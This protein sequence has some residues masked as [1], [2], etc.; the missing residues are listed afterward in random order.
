MQ[1]DEL[2]HWGVKGMK[3]G[4]RKTPEQKAA[5]I[6]RRIDKQNAKAAKYDKQVSN[7]RNN[8][9]AAA[10]ST[11]LTVNAMYKIKKVGTIGS[12][13][14]KEPTGL[15]VATTATNLPQ[16]QQMKRQYI[17]EESRRKAA[18]LQAKLD[19]VQGKPMKD[20]DTKKQKLTFDSAKARV[21]AYAKDP[22]NQ[23][24]AVVR[25]EK[26]VKTAIYIRRAVKTA[27]F[28]AMCKLTYDHYISNKRVPG[29]KALS[30]ETISTQIEKGLKN[31]KA[32]VVDFDGIVRPYKMPKF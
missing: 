1:A 13:L 8:P 11:G 9:V 23:R 14:F 17:A 18:K 30:A 27:M 10:V 28:I 25:T 26:S 3:W 32:Y 7:V 21:K 12:T 19:R 6:R 24:K 2:Q 5:S 15:A 29:Q 16:Y 31:G 4:V 22:H 20:V